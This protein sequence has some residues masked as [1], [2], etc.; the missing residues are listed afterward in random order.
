MNLWGCS[1]V[2]LCAQSFEPW[3][4]MHNTG[5]DYLFN[6]RIRHMDLHGALYNNHVFIYLVFVRTS[7]F[8]INRNMGHYVGFDDCNCYLPRSAPK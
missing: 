6:K 8:D 4:A 7:N 2:Q 1:V 3:V 5:V